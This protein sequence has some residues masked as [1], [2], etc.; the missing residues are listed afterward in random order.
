MSTATAP[1]RARRPMNSAAA[2]PPPAPVVA[3]PTPAAAP[4]EMIEAPVRPARR[5][6]GSRRQRLDNTPIPG[7]QC[8]WFN[9]LP[10]RIQQA[11]EAGYE[12]VLDADGKPVQTVG[13]VMEGGGAI[14]AYR[15]KIPHEW[16]AQDQ[17]LK[18]EPRALIDRQMRGEEGK[19]GRYSSEGR[20]GFGAI[21]RDGEKAQSASVAMSTEGRQKSGWLP[22]DP[23]P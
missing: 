5:P 10:G 17:A 22:P 14:K 23:Q 12:H 6:F 15:M 9:D 2:P 1:T 3:A 21:G 8:Y 13:G 19:D 11:K 4:V 16:Y 7:Y 18:E 20:P